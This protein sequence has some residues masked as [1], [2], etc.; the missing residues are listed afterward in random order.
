VRRNSQRQVAPCIAVADSVGDPSVGIRANSLHQG[1]NYC[2]HLRPFSMTTTDFTTS[3]TVGQSPKEVFDAV[4]NVRGWWSEEID[5]E[6][7][8]QGDEFYYHHKNVHECWI[9]LIEV[10]PNSKVEWLVKENYFDFTEDEREWR[11]T[12]IVFEITPGNGK[13]ELRFTHVGLVSEY[14]CYEV[15]QESWRHYINHSLYNL[16][17]RGKG[18]PNAKE[19]GFNATMV[20][21]WKLSNR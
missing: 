7:V 20:E 21:K 3:F 8:H 12:H 17:T 16:I 1:L 19:G 10:I 4:T 6:T 18:S 2:K 13:T 14:E 5:G 9:K 11:G 15:C